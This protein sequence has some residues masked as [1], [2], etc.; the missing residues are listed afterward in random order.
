[1]ETVLVVDDEPTLRE[2][3]VRYLERAG[4]RAL[5]AG[6]GDEAEVLLRNQPPDLVILDLMLPGTD[7]LE[8]CRRIREDSALP[9]IMLT[10]GR[11]QTGSSGWSSA[12]TT[13]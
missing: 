12:P 9:V 2:V 4:Y 10:A 7:G 5:E 8:L 3:V 13:M 1:M 11:R 6:D